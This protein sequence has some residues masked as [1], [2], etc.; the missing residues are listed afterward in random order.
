MQ[1]EK[2]LPF[3]ISLLIV[4]YNSADFVETSLYALKKLSKNT[5]QV[6]ILDNGSKMKDY[7]KLKISASKYEN[8]TLER[9]ETVLTGSLAH[10][11]ALNKLIKKVNTPYFSILDADAI[12]LKKDWDEILISKITGKIKVVGTQAPPS[13]PQDFPIMFAILFETKS[14]NALNIDFRPT[15][16]KKTQDTGWKLRESYF[17]AGY[18]G[19]N[20]EYRPTRTYKDGPFKNITGVHEFYFENNPDIFACHFG[21]GSNPLAKQTLVSKNKFLR[22]ILIPFNFLLWH[23][24]KRHWIQICRNIIDNQ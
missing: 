8:V 14:F 3:N 22:L 23:K 19:L 24:N 17:Q 9:S 1:T 15:D 5:Y 18:S 2:I 6:F 10:G 4:N 21:R 13:K 20:I 11:T 7:Q 12:W 16:L